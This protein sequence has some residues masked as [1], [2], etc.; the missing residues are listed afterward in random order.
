[1]YLVMINLFD[2]FKKDKKIVVE[3][4]NVNNPITDHI[5]ENIGKFQVIFS[6]SRKFI[7]LKNAKVAGTSMYRGI[8]KREILDLVS[9]KDNP[10]EF[11]QWWDNLTDRKLKK[12]FKFTFV[13]NPF[14]R[15]VSAFSHIIIEGTVNGYHIDM[16]LIEVGGVEDRIVN[17]RGVLDTKF[18]HMYLLFS[19]FIMRVL[20]DYD[21]NKKSV[22]WM[23]Q[24]ILSH[25]NKKPIVDFIGKYENLAND[26]RYVADKIQ[27]N[28]TLP[29]VSS[30]K[31]QKVTN[32]TRQEMHKVHWKGYYFSNEIVSA[33]LDYYPEDF[34]LLGYRPV[35]LALQQRIKI[36]RDLL[37]AKHNS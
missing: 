32:K 19:L 21:I 36:R 31:S 28:T 30:S 9:Y 11:D 25:Y 24:N 35:A 22:H 14:D 3:V 2:I 37:D 34:D 29:F 8:M 20:P 17:E 13:R 18:D 5:K 26:W 33:I 23:P 27:V 4:V 1:M 12:Y 15:L 6:P 10:T 16:D 7:W